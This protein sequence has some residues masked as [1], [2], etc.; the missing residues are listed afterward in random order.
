MASTS[1]N[2]P[3][4]AIY[5]Q[6]LYEAAEA[7][8]AL[9]QVGAEVAGLN[10]ALKKDRRFAEFFESPTISFE[11]KRKVLDEALKGHSVITRNLLLVITERGRSQIFGEIV[12]AFKV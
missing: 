2:R 8:H 12:E 6:A 1:S 3:L 4:A 9:E 10:E 11:A 7:A 5:A